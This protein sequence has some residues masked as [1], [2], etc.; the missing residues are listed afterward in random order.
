[1]GE[2]P[3]R[4]VPSGRGHGPATR[5][6]APARRCRRRSC[7]RYRAPPGCPRTRARRNAPSRRRC[8]RSHGRGRASAPSERRSGAAHHCPSR[9]AAPD[10]ARTS[11]AL[12]GRGESRTVSVRVLELDEARRGAAH[13]RGPAAV[14]HERSQQALAGDL[15]SR[16][17]RVAQGQG[18]P[19]PATAG[20]RGAARGAARGT[21]R[22][23]NSSSRGISHR[24]EIERGRVRQRRPQCDACGEQR[25]QPAERGG[26]ASAAPYQQPRRIARTAAQV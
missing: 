2:S 22:M 24:N 7:P 13:V 8:R 17:Q 18:G 12:D 19:P 23:R 9:A 4:R 14:P 16:A 1:M 20:S 10:R 11:A 26:A 5:P 15:G 25:P 21:S 6:N 3:R